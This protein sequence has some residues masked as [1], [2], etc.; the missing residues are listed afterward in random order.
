[1]QKYLLICAHLVGI[2][3]ETC[4]ITEKMSGQCVC[5]FAKFGPICRDAHTNIF[6]KIEIFCRDWEKGS[7]SITGGPVLTHALAT[8]TEDSEHMDS[9][10]LDYFILNFHKIY[11]IILS[12][13]HPTFPVSNVTIIKRKLF[14]ENIAF[15]TVLVQKPTPTRLKWVSY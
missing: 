8:G 1:M 12:E 9:W 11:I 5:H 15:I 3:H 6:R 10:F 7:P 14:F 2:V 13:C 4:Q